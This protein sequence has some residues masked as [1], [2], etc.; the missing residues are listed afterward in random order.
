MFG[1]VCAGVSVG[2]ALIPAR[3]SIKHGRRSFVVHVV[4]AGF[5]VVVV[6]LLH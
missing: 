3:V 4:V 6:L 1:D 2:L 5:I